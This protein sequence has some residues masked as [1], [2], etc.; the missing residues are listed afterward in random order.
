MNSKTHAKPFTITTS[1]SEGT[2]TLTTPT[3][4][5]IP[6]GRLTEWDLIQSLERQ[7]CH[8]M[9]LRQP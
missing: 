7:R 5:V 1:L 3:G 2:M 8:Y 6:T 4:R 9:L